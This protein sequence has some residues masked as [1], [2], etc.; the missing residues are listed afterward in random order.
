MSQNLEESPIDLLQNTKDRLPDFEE[1]LKELEELSS[2][3]PEPIY[4]YINHCM[5]R[6]EK[7]ETLTD[8]ERTSLI[9]FCLLISIN[10]LKCNALFTSAKF[11]KLTVLGIIRILEQLKELK[12]KT[13]STLENAYNKILEMTE[14]KGEV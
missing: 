2:K 6:L 13:I 7:W 12:K 1:I 8:E 5:V 3:L 4:I 10:L 14:A 9:K 11:D